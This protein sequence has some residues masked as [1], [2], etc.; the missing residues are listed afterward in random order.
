MVSPKAP[1]ETSEEPTA[2]MVAMPL[3]SMIAGTIRKPP[4]IPK[5]PDRNP[6]TRP[7]HDQTKRDRRIDP[8]QGIAAGGAAAEHAGGDRQHHQ[9][10]Q[11]Q[12]MLAVDVPA[13]KGAQRRARNAGEREDQW[14]RAISRFRRARARSDWRR[15]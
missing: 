5:K 12:Q 11:E 4:P 3:P 7:V 6:T 8:H 14:R 13:Q 2:L 9:P 1:T 10:E 15:H